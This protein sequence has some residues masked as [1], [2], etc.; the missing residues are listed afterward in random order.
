M[1]ANIAQQLEDT[2]THLFHKL[3][4][5]EDLS[6]VLIALV[7]RLVTN[8][9]NAAGIRFSEVYDCGAGE[10]R[11]R[12]YPVFNALILPPKLIFKNDLGDYMAHKNIAL[13][14]V[15]Q[16]N[17]AVA[18]FFQELIQKI[19]RFAEWKRIPFPELK[20]VQGSAIISKDDEFKLQVGK[21][22]FVGKIAKFVGR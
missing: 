3:S 1:T 17:K 10:F 18:D 16:S 11:A 6:N 5:N 9:R 13:A 15:L 12:I 19:E 2:K 20:V 8:Y 4:S 21:E 14:G 22:S 7:G